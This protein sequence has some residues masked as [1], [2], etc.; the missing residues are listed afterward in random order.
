MLYILFEI[1]ENYKAARAVDQEL[2]HAQRM[3][4]FLESKCAKLE[5]EG[6]L[7]AKK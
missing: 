1:I 2:G 4:K 6:E 5:Q 7:L 3:I